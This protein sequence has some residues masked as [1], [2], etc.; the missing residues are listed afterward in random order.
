MKNLK[1]FLFITLSLLTFYFL[2]YSDTYPL[3]ITGGVPINDYTLFANSGWDGNWYVGYNM[4]WI[5]RFPVEILPKNK[6]LFSKVY[7]GVKLGRAKIQQKPNSA[8]W[9]KNVIDGKIYTAIS[10]THAWKSNQRYFLCSVKDIP[11][12]GDW[13]NAI[14]T[15]GEAKWFYTEVSLQDIN[16]N[17]DLWVCVYS[18]T[19]Y[20][21]S[22][23]SSPIL[24]GGWR[25]RGQKDI[26]VWLNNQIKGVPPLKPDTALTTAIRAFDPAIV[27]K[28]IP[29]NS[30][31]EVKIRIA[32]IVDGRKDTDEKV[33]FITAE[34]PNIDR[35]WLEISQDGTS[36]TRISKY[37]YQQPYAFNLNLQSVPEEISGDFF[38]RFAANDIFENVGYTERIQLNIT[39]GIEE[40]NNTTT[41]TQ[42]QDTKSKDK[43]KKK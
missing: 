5:K 42:V 24:A 16:L 13:E 8:P 22:A 39:R 15:T 21:T 27:L 38:I 4:C 43:R 6:D 10:S 12:E 35:V 20:L 37:V 18:D 2:S 26:N 36:W 17:S 23:S 34:T 30:P 1:K 32:N 40:K 29:K 11:T 33:F 41:T 7:I 19:N 3:Y 25:E 28:F 9:E 14:T 31:S